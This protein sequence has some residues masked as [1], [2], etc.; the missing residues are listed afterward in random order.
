MPFTE[1]GSFPT[2]TGY[3]SPKPSSVHSGDGPA[4]LKFRPLPLKVQNATPCRPF[5]GIGPIPFGPSLALHL[6]FF[7]IR[8]HPI[9][10]QAP[11]LKSQAL[12][13]VDFPFQSQ[14]TPLPVWPVRS[15][16]YLPEKG[17]FPY[18]VPDLFFTR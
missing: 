7:A 13:H 18:S 11:P 15:P 16:V 6:T 9:L 5:R 8:S 10:G 14:L 3:P 17:I 12:F 1:L 4:F 2:G